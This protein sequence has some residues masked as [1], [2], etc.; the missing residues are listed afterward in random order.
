MATE[1]AHTKT[2]DVAV[3]Q[4]HSLRKKNP[5]ARNVDE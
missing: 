5:C 4:E 3:E 1:S 2:G